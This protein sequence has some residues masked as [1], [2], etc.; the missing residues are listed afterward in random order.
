MD[1]DLKKIA[2]R[3]ME[4]A[5]EMCSSKSVM[6]D[7]YDYFIYIAL[8]CDVI[9]FLVLRNSMNLAWLISFRAC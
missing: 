9:H 3:V 5:K 4:K 8:N 6:T 1:A 7:E 2:A